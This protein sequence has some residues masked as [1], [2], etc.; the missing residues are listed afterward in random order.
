MKRLITAAVLILAFSTVSFA[1]KQVV[2]EG[3]THS[4][5]GNYKIE[6]L[7]AP[8]MING[9]EL[10]A[11]TI[12]YENTVMKAIVAIDKTFKCKKY[13]V[14][15]PNLSIQYVCNGYYFGVER[16]DKNLEKEGYKTSNDDLDNFQYYHQKVLSCGDNDDLEN[17][18]LIAAYFPFL[19]RNTEEVLAM[20]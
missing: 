11:F 9:K 16:L 6:T 1:K 15:T 3:K 12:S 2:A 10:K 5:L 14:L 13:Y 18:R 17:T 8:V 4:A 7:D 20:K 19:L